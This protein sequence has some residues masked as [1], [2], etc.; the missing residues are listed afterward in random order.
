MRLLDWLSTGNVYVTLGF[1]RCPLN[2]DETLLLKHFDI[3]V[4]DPR[5]SEVKVSSDGTSWVPH[6]GRNTE[7]VVLPDLQGLTLSL[8]YNEN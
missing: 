3:R 5:T 7:I 6:S 2:P 1:E 8:S 4:V